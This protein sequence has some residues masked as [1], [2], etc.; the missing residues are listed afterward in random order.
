MSCINNWVLYYN[1]VYPELSRACE[2][3]VY[4]MQ[5]NCT[6]YDLF[7]YDKATKNI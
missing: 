1:F 3:D 5:E 2:Q 4:L 7:K 6:L